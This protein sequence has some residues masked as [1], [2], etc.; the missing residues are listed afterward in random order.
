MKDFA[1]RPIK[2][3]WLILLPLAISA[4]SNMMVQGRIFKYGSTIERRPE[5]FKQ[6]VQIGVG[7]KLRTLPKMV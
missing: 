6:Y 4:A 5:T 1:L 3:Q 2:P 7:P